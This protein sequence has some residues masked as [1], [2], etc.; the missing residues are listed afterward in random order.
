ME[1]DQET[2]KLDANSSSV[3]RIRD[4]SI[5]FKCILEPN[6]TNKSSRRERTQWRYSTDDKK[7]GKLPPGVRNI[8]E[9]EIFI[10]QVNKTHQGYYLCKRNNVS[11]VALL[12]VKGLFNQLI[13]YFILKEKFFFRSIC[14]TL[15]IY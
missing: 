8:S 11:F 12:R 14:S 15:A 3:R 6:Q 1:T 4:K 2:D 7:Y 5:T 13:I 9:N 10:G